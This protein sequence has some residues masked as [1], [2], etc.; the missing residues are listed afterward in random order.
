MTDKDRELAAVVKKLQLVP[1]TIEGGYFRVTYQ[2]SEGTLHS[3]LPQRFDGDRPFCSEIY[4]ILCPGRISSF[5]RMLAD[6]TYHFY[7]GGP[8]HVYEITPAGEV[9]ETI[10]GPDVLAGQQPQHTISA[11]NWL[12]SH[13]VNDD[14]WALIGCTVAPAMALEDYTHGLR[15][16]LLKAFPQHRE[17]IERLTW[18]TVGP[19]PPYLEEKGLA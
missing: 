7:A 4:Y 13:C 8:L 2:A 18:D 11:G 16:D 15:P 12:G 14:D 10:M 6:M 3:F 1:H 5:H 9:L 19:P 17:L